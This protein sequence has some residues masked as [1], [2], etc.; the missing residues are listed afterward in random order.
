MKKVFAFF[1][2][3]GMAQMALAED[4][5]VS[6]VSSGIKMVEA[7]IVGTGFE[8]NG[9]VVVMN[10]SLKVGE[11]GMTLSANKIEQLNP[12]ANLVCQSLNRDLVDYSVGSTWGKS[13]AFVHQTGAISTKTNSGGFTYKSLNSVTCK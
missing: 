3:V 9:Q 13:L 12:A 11:M 10:P 8:I 7:K 5:Q 6:K 2:M 1:L 4:V